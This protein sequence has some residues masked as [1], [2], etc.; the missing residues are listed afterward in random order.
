MTARFINFNGMRLPGGVRVLLEVT[1]NEAYIQLLSPLKEVYVSFYVSSITFLNSTSAAGV[2][3]SGLVCKDSKLPSCEDPAYPTRAFHSVANM[4]STNECA[5]RGKLVLVAQIVFTDPYQAHRFRI[6][7]DTVKCAFSECDNL[8]VATA[9]DLSCQTLGPPPFPAALVD[10]MSLNLQQQGYPS[11][12]QRL[13]QRSA[14]TMAVPPPPNAIGPFSESP[15]Y[16]DAAVNN[17]APVCPCTPDPAEEAA[18]GQE[19]DGCRE[20]FDPY[21]Y[22]L[23]DEKTLFCAKACLAKLDMDRTWLEMQQGYCKVIQCANGVGFVIGFESKCC[24]TQYYLRRDTF[25]E[26]APKTKYGF[27]YKVVQ[28]S[29]GGTEISEYLISFKN[30]EDANN[31]KAVVDKCHKTLMMTAD[32]GF[33]NTGRQGWS[34]CA[35]NNNNNSNCCCTRTPAHRGHHR[36]DNVLPGL[37][38]LGGCSDDDDDVRYHVLSGSE[39]NANWNNSLHR[40]DFSENAEIMNRRSSELIESLVEFKSRHC[41]LEVQ[42]AI[43]S[44]DLYKVLNRLLFWIILGTFARL[45][46]HVYVVLDQEVRVNNRIEIAA[47]KI[48][49][50]HF[51]SLSIRSTRNAYRNNGRVDK[52]NGRCRRILNFIHLLLSLCTR[53]ISSKPNLE[54]KLLSDNSALFWKSSI[55]DL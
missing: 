13:Q 31:F 43:L 1:Q 32:T 44:A 4:P 39:S 11:P 34:V 35:N 52:V 33:D 7:L 24:I 21:A 50:I 45:N 49:R 6:V 23:I 15:R 51:D 22:E 19:N 36:M 53:Y 30:C 37:G 27:I 12:R 17:T 20:L 26:R 18:D 10:P 40:V 38:G 28:S 42:H 2:A 5:N 3:W 48:K 8:V 41:Y 25:F 47:D 46:L 55:Y 16:Y 9:G 54:R 14:V 29:D